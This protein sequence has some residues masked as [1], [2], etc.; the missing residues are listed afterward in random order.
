MDVHFG[1]VVDLVPFCG[2][3]L[4]VTVIQWDFKVGHVAVGWRVDVSVKTLKH[5]ALGFS[6]YDA[7]DD[8]SDVLFSLCGEVDLALGEELVPMLVCLIYD[9]S[10][11]SFG[12]P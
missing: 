3:V 11:L 4:G 2:W 8:A 5:F 12:F 9:F 1:D 7:F 6:M 10:K